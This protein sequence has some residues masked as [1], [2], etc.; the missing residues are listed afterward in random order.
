MARSYSMDRRAYLATIGAVGTTTVAGCLGDDDVIVPG[1]APGFPPFE[2]TRDGELV[3]FDID[4]AEAVI[5]EAGYEADDWVEVEFDS[6]IPSLTGDD[7][8]LVAAAMTITEDRAETIAFSD[9]YYE[10]DQAVLVRSDDDSPPDEE[11]DLAGR[12]VGAQGGTTG[13]GEVERMI[14]DGTVNEDDYRQYDNYTLAVSDLESGNVDAIVVDIPVA[15]NFEASRDVAI[16]FIIETGEEFGFGM[17]Q[18]DDR[19]DDINSGLATVQNDGT[20]E[21]LVEEWFE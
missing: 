11:D 1:T 10:S 2:F 7:I 8:D 20:Y 17:R 9:P 19:L 14:D 21:D 4:L 15:N 6:L 16:A 12:R 3:G 5:E 13:E 18:D